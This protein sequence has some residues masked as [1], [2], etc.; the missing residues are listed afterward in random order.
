MKC[1]DNSDRVEP[2]NNLPASVGKQIFSLLSKEVVLSVTVQK[3]YIKNLF[4]ESTTFKYLS[5][6]NLHNRV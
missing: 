6:T 4:E 3:G 2:E 1:F 5:I